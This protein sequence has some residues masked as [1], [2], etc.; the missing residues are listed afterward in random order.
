MYILKRKIT[1]ILISCLFIISIPAYALILPAISFSR[2]SSFKTPSSNP[3]SEL[4]ETGSGCSANFARLLDVN[5]DEIISFYLPNIKKTAKNVNNF[6]ILTLINDD[7]VIYMS[8]GIYIFNKVQENI[9]NSIG[10]LLFE[11]LQEKIYN[12]NEIFSQIEALPLNSTFNQKLNIPDNLF[13]FVYEK[14][15]GG[16][17]ERYIISQTPHEKQLILDSF[18]PESLETSLNK[19]I[20]NSLNKILEGISFL[21]KVDYH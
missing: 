15:V 2:T 18:Y 6:E 3:I 8:L 5:K 9:S 14:K 7:R 19:D 21:D 11:P 4:P 17:I 1:L 16:F 12:D 13:V 20:V 10:Y